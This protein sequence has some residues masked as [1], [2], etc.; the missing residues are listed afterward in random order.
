MVVLALIGVH[1]LLLLW[2]EVYS[3]LFTVLSWLV[4]LFINPE[5]AIWLTAAT[6]T[7]WGMIFG[8]Q[9]K[10]IP[11]G[12]QEVAP[13]AA[14]F[15]HRLIMKAVSPDSPTK[16]SPVLPLALYGGL[17]LVAMAV[18]YITRVMRT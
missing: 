4:L 16:I 14:F 9:G 1:L 18:E 6:F 5:W 7:I 15:D 12:Y 3:H 2:Q 8:Q 13:K 17:C 10:H 11:L